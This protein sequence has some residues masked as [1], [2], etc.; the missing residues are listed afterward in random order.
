MEDLVYEIKKY[1]RAKHMRLVVKP[2]GRVVVTMPWRL[3]QYLAADF[4]KKQYDWIV[5]AQEKMRT[6]L[7]VQRGGTE[8]EY[9]KH[10]ARALVVLSAR[11]EELNQYYNFPYKRVSI[12]NQKTRWGSCSRT[13]TISLSYRLLFLSPE[14]QDYVLVHE[15]CHVA[16]M[17]HSARFWGLVGKVIP[18][19]KALRSQLHTN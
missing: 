18:N 6:V 7:P 17:N 14:L 5:K 19:Y 1:K 2:G 13:G 12:R 10:R 8:A 16:E 11:L 4:V 15:L 9:K 3:P